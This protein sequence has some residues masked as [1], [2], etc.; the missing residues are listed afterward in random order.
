MIHGRVLT[1]KAVHK[2]TQQE[3]HDLLF[4]KFYGRGLQYLN[5]TIW[6]GMDERTCKVDKFYVSPAQA[7]KLNRQRGS[8]IDPKDVS[9]FR[10][11]LSD[12]LGIAAGMLNAQL[13]RMAWK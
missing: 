10:R 11:P 8:F 1:F 5:S 7:V 4:T 12:Q 3:V 9:I 6:R 2:G 13:K